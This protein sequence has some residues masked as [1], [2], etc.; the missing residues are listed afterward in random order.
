MRH[1]FR[2]ENPAHGEPCRVPEIKQKPGGAWPAPQGY[3]R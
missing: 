1:L 3:I 2:T